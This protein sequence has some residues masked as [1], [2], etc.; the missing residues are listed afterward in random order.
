MAPQGFERGDAASGVP[1]V[2]LTGRSLDWS[3]L[4]WNDN[5]IGRPTGDGQLHQFS[6]NRW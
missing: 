4:P 5:G 3:E 2:A 6:P 1:D